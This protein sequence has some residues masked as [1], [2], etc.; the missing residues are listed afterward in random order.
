MK[1]KVNDKVR[2]KQTNLLDIRRR[3]E[4]QFHGL[5]M[6]PLDATIIGFTGENDYLI[7]IQDTTNRNAY[8]VRCSE[9]W[10]E[11]EQVI[12][13]NENNSEKFFDEEG[14][15]ADLKMALGEYKSI[16]DCIKSPI[17]NVCDNLKYFL[18]EK[19][20]RYGNSALE[21][22][23]I[24]SKADSSE[25]I[26]V[27]LDDKINRIKNSNEDRENDYLDLM[28]YIVL[29]MVKKGWDDFKKYLD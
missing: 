3:I 2:I 23:R 21:P 11:Q 16:R 6:I 24:F 27:R 25:Q 15:E 17:E 28:G 22:A 26:K 7:E 18:L 5:F 9:D 4:N 14:D 19:N 10:L 20:R 12:K 29:F 13:C 1:F 8:H